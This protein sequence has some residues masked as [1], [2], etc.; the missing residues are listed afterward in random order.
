MTIPACLPLLY[1]RSVPDARRAAETAREWG[2]R[3]GGFQP[4]PPDPEWPNAEWDR[5]AAAFFDMMRN[6]EDFD[7][8]R[9]AFVA[10]AGLAGTRLALALL[11]FAEESAE[12]VFNLV[13]ASL[14]RI[15][16][17][18]PSHN[19]LPPGVQAESWALLGDAYRRVGK[20]I[21]A[22]VAF[23]RAFT[24][25]DESTDAFTFAR[26]EDLYARMERDRGALAE[27]VE[28]WLSAL[29][30]YKAAGAEAAVLDTAVRLASVL[31]EA[32]EPL[33]AEDLC[34]GILGSR[35]GPMLGSCLVREAAQ[36]SARGRDAV[37]GQI[38]RI[39]EAGLMGHVSVLERRDL[40]GL[41]FDRLA[42]RIADLSPGSPA[43]NVA[44][45]TGKAYSQWCRAQLLFDRPVARGLF[46]LTRIRLA[47]DE[48]FTPDL[49]AT[50]AYFVV[51]PE[52]PTRQGEPTP[53]I[54]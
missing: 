43:R 11:G 50:L 10:F 2:K 23:Q 12:D 38:E 39:A 30:A 1:S 51:P 32:G 29:E 53:K 8:Y 17:A 9:S 5:L 54:H 31:C 7:S 6:P 13:R 49:S 24:S 33:M 18:N 21:H 15:Q 45:D 20:P 14:Y 36:L 16:H 25:I 28:G 40:A 44:S 47:E 19:V 4:A 42:E 27:A 3:L 35:P 22:E 26:V 46:A 34:Q 37:V 41:R 52:P 48:N